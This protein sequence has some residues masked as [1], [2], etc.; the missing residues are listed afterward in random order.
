ML[1]EVQRLIPK[2]LGKSRVLGIAILDLLHILVNVE[3]LWGG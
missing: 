3:L 1:C 2:V